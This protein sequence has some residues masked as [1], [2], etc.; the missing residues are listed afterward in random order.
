MKIII[1]VVDC[2]RADHVSCYGYHR[3][4]TPNIDALARDG[5]LFEKAFSPSTWTKPVAASLLTG[6]YPSAHGLRMRTD[7]LSWN[8]RTLPELLGEYGYI[9]LAIS[10]IGNVSSSLGFGKGFDSFIDLYK[11]PSLLTKRPVADVKH[12]KLYHEKQGE[13]VFP[14]AEDINEALFPWIKKHINQNFFIFLWAMDPHDPYNP[15]EDW[16]P[17]VDPRY[18]GRMDGSRE[19]AKQAKRP[20]D[21]QHLINLYDS[22]IAYTDHCFGQLVT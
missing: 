9:T 6:L 7:I 12:E 20:E 8:I 3:Q 11:E 16:K 22:E 14:L 21:L 2:L 4:T 17:Y 10:T 1:Y 18:K 19:L 5:V 15:P 13:V